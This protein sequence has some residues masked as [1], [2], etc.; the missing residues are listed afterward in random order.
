MFTQ[1]PSSFPLPMRLNAIPL[2]HVQTPPSLTR[3]EALRLLLVVAHLLSLLQQL[4]GV[5]DSL[6]S[7][8]GSVD[9]LV[10]Q[11]AWNDNPEG[12]HQDKVAPVVSGLGAGVGNVED[13][14]VEQR[15]CV[16]QDIAVELTE[17]DNELERVAQRVVNG[18]EV[19]SDEGEGSPEGLS[20]LVS[21]SPC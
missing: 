19:G 21:N 1:R 10:H 12:V 14:V 5:I 17:R 18:N 4:G 6:E 3:I 7:A 8:N 9:A 11:V 15:G 16:V 20:K 13:V 2:Q